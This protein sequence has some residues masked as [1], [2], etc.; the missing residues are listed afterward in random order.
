MISRG[1]ASRIDNKKM[2]SR[3]IYFAAGGRSGASAARRAAAY[4]LVACLLGTPAHAASAGRAAGELPAPDLAANAAVQQLAYRIGPFDTLA[5]SVFGVD[6]L[7]RE[8]QVD[9]AGQIDFPLIGAVQASA[10]TPTELSA[11]IAAKLGDRYL[12]SP[13][14]SVVVK[15]SVSQRFTVE[16]AVASPGLYEFRGGMTLLQAI[17]TAKGLN[18][19]ASARDVVVF[20]LVEGRRMAGAADLRAIRAGEIGD[21]QIYPGDVIVVGDSHAKG[22]LRGIIG[23]MPIFNLLRL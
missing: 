2:I 10:R 9:N 17:A 7:T 3:R 12:Q 14:V 8:V 21:P 6:A 15:E 13:Q 11:A 16:G 4:A 1:Y 19:V 5:I 18:D 20:R 23:A 22:W